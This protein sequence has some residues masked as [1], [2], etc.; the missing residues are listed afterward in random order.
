MNGD[1]QV[2]LTFE[3]HSSYQK[4]QIYMC[5]RLFSIAKGELVLPS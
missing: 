3:T 1:L 2:A 4:A 5:F